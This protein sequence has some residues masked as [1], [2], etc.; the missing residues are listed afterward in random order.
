MGPPGKNAS[1]QL[2]SQAMAF[3]PYNLEQLPC[4]EHHKNCAEQATARGYSPKYKQASCV[5]QCVAKTAKEL[6]RMELLWEK[7]Y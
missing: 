5:I 2:A 3:K 1:F 4:D 6:H 7:A